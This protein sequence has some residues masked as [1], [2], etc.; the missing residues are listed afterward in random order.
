MN[1]VSLSGRL[2]K[3]PEVTAT[4]TSN[5]EMKVAKYTLA[6][7]RNY[8]S[9]QNVDWINITAFGRLAENAEKY[10]QKGMLINVCGRI[11]TSSY[12]NREGKKVYTTDVI[13]S[14]QEFGESKRD[15]EAR[16]ERAEQSQAPANDVPASTTPAT[17]PAHQTSAEDWMTIPDGFDEAV[18]FA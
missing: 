9:Q 16:K 10:F 2:A 8:K 14:E 7:R 3:D 1:N 4:Q 18:P 17:V 15:F 5:G 6:V 11:Q 12:T 13:A